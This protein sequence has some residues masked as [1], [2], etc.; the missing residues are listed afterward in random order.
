VFARRKEIEADVQQ[1]YNTKRKRI[2]RQPKLAGVNQKVL[3][4]IDKCNSKAY[5]FDAE[6][7]C[8]SLLSLIFFSFSVK[9]LVHL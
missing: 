1:G 9:V 8:F 3:E 6:I 4:I 5:I 7:R 2:R